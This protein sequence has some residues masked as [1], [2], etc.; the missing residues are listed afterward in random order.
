MEPS[1]ENETLER[2]VLAELEIPAVQDLASGPAT[3]LDVR[4]DWLLSR[5]ARVQAEIKRNS[6][7][8]TARVQQIRTWEASANESLDRQC[9][10]L[11]HLISL[12]GINYD[13]GKKR[14]RSLPNG[15]V[16]FRKRPPSV[17]IW[18]AEKAVA[19]AL[20]RGIKVEQKTWVGKTELRKH[21][22]STGELPEGAIDGVEYVEGG[23]VFYV[24]P[25]EAP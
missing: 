14:S 13:Y 2:E 5:L 23:D 16:G 6:D 10:Y 11:E 22:E 4:L 19:F 9:G 24:T 20:Q 8:A 21:I 18:D 15:T 3:E 25:K 7:V 17:E 12:I 1:M